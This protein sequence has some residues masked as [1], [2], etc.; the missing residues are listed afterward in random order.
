MFIDSCSSTVLSYARECQKRKPTGVLCIW[1]QISLKPKGKR[2]PVHF[3]PTHHAINAGGNRSH[4]REWLGPGSQTWGRTLLRLEPRSLD[5]FHLDCHVY[6][7]QGH[8]MIAHILSYC[9]G[10]CFKRRTEVFQSTHLQLCLEIN[11][12]LDPLKQN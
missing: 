1:S 2:D 9:G 3:Q 10:N 8:K 11:L 12:Q 7:G 6:F 4:G 5:Q